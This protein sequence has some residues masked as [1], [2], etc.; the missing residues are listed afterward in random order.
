VTRK[1]TYKNSK[2]KIE[3]AVVDPYSDPRRPEK[4]PNMEGGGGVDTNLIFVELD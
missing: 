3:S 4:P 2:I 1:A